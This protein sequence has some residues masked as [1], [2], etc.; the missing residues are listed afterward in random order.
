[1]LS[2]SLAHNQPTD[3]I[4]A[5]LSNFDLSMWHQIPFDRGGG[6]KFF[7][8]IN[9]WQIPILGMLSFQLHKLGLVCSSWYLCTLYIKHGFGSWVGFLTVSWLRQE[10]CDKRGFIK[11]VERERERFI[12]FAAS[13]GTSSGI[14]IC[15]WVGVS[16][17]R[18]CGVCR[19]HFFVGKKVRFWTLPSKHSSSS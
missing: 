17:C 18:S 15:S 5:L 7:F 8:K 12:Q 13:S 1:M 10:S 3:S 14:Y 16:N 11:I 9:W 6:G 4:T 19:S 2:S